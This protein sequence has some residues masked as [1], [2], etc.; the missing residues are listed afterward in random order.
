MIIFQGDW[1][2]NENGT[3]A[4]LLVLCLLLGSMT[5]CASPKATAAS[6]TEGITANTV[7]TQGALT[8]EALKAARDFA[9]ALWHESLAKEGENT[10]VSPLSVFLALGMTANGAQEDTLSAFQNVLGLPLDTLNLVS[11]ALAEKLMGVSGSTILHIANS[12]W[13]DEDFQAHEEFLQTNVDYFD[14][15]L[16][17]AFR[18]QKQR[19]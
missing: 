7:D 2:A 9:T 17:S 5:G 11:R 8:E 19:Q 6:L 12:I 13:Y 14:A 1:L 4:L 10:L 15:A 3:T 16:P 18:K